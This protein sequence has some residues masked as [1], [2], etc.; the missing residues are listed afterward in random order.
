MRILQE[1][2]MDGVTQ[3]RKKYLKRRV[4]T[5][6]VCKF[7]NHTIHN[8]KKGTNY[9]WHMDKCIQGDMF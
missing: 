8:L 6:K 1:M 2:D 3:T 7:L 9:L 4:Y 5:N